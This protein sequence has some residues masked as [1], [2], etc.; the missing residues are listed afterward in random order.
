MA[1]G[2]LLRHEAVEQSPLPLRA[3]ATG[4]HGQPGAPCGRDGLDREHLIA[5]R[6]DEA[7]ER[8]SAADLDRVDAAGATR[9]VEAGR[10]LLEARQDTRRPDEGDA[11]GE[12]EPARPA[13]GLRH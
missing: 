11:A 10:V 5:V 13:A 3:P 9:G 6:P 12:S 7:A 8:L 1:L 2:L 4:D